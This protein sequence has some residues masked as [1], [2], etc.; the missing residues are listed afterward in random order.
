M[1]PSQLCHLN[2]RHPC[3]FDRAGAGDTNSRFQES[4]LKV[5]QN[6]YP[7][8]AALF[9]KVD[10]CTPPASHPAFAAVLDLQPAS[11]ALKLIKVIL[12]RIPIQHPPQRL[13]LLLR[14]FRNLLVNILEQTP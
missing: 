10:T 1:A 4:V 7:R 8:S 5:G 2:T 13:H 6:Q 11:P 9:A 12:L 3:K 14:L